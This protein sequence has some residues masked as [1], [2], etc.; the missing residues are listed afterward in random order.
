MIYPAC[1]V[2]TRRVS[3][4]ATVRVTPSE[5]VWRSLRRELRAQWGAGRGEHV[6]YGGVNVER[7]GSVW[8]ELGV[9]EGAV[10]QVEWKVPKLVNENIHAAAEIWCDGST[11][12]TERDCSL[13]SYSREQLV[14]EFGEIV[15]EML[16]IPVACLKGR[17]CSQGGRCRK[18]TAAEQVPPRKRYRPPKR[19][20][21]PQGAAR[22]QGGPAQKAKPAEKVESLVR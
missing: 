16:W 14:E 15:V 19:P 1:L 4:Q 7:V 22:P 3:L 17:Y 12:H 8:R 18:G 13:R 6:E 21:R 9:E 20:A 2:V 5:D 10:V 11:V